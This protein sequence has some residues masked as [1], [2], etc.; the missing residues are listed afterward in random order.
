MSKRYSYNILLRE[1]NKKKQKIK[2]VYKFLKIIFVLIII[3]GI[4]YKI[5][6]YISSN[7]IFCIQNVYLC[8]NE[9]TIPDEVIY[10][11]I[12]SKTLNIFNYKKII[13]QIQNLFPEI[14]NVKVVSIPTKLLKIKIS[15]F[16]PIGYKK[17][18]N[19]EI[20]FFSLEKGWYKV[21]DP[22]KINLN[23]LC[24]IDGDTD[25]SLLKIIYQKFNEISAWD[26][27][28]KISVSKNKSVIFFNNNNSVV[29]FFI[30][31]KKFEEV[32][33]EQ[34]VKLLK[35]NFDNN[36]KVYTQLLSQG[37]VYIE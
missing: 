8:Q 15:S 2:I 34:L 21:Y 9:T 16:Y 5:N 36:K 18:S 29:S 11:Y 7:K 28:K 3:V 10:K 14:K 12:N 37:R 23:G 22:T 32:K 19:K 27:V 31:N 6:K 20:C 25:I 4:Y 13:Y 24:E 35:Y 17:E 30:D 1:K 26:K 33:K